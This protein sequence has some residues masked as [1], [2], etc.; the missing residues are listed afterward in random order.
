MKQVPQR[1]QSEHWETTSYVLNIYK[2]KIV[3]FDIHSKEK[4]KEPVQNF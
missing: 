3:I 4:V 1:D 2:L